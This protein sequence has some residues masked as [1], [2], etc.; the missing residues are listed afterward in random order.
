M[1]S[2]GRGCKA[3]CDHTQDAQLTDPSDEPWGER[4][5][6]AKHTDT[7]PAT[8]PVTTP[9]TVEASGS[10]ATPPEGF[11][12]MIEV[13]GWCYYWREDAIWSTKSFPGNC[14]GPFLFGYVAF[15]AAV[16]HTARLHTHSM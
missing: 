5:R 3:L 2:Q 9:V 14:S 13:G 11:A 7:T 12:A 15:D 4:R 6:V 16:R 8:V 10:Q 1:V